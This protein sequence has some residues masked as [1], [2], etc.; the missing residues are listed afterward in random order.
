MDDV[1]GP[2][3]PVWAQRFE[4][5]RAAAGDPAQLELVWQWRQLDTWVSE[6]TAGKSA[7]QLQDELTELLAARKR[8]SPAWSLR[9]AWRRMAANLGPRE[10][11]ALTAYLKAATRFGKTGG[12]FAQRWITEM[13]IALDQAKTAVPV[14]IMPTAKALTS[15]RPSATPP[16]DVLIVDEA[17]QIGFDALPLLSL[18]NT[19]IIVG[20]DKQTSPENVGL[21]RQQIFDMMDDFLTGLP[22]Y[23]TLFDPD[24]SLYDLARERF[25]DADHAQGALPLPAGHHRLLEPHRLRERDHPA[26]GPGAEDRLDAA[27]AGPG[28]RRLPNSRCQRTR[29]AAGRRADHPNSATTPTTPA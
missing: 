3:T 2:P 20:D 23:R 21:D 25:A 12:K 19:A 7:S 5:D 6:L 1:P 22:G 10:R 4:S 18:A 24:S 11:Q 16:F 8:T 14:W 26:P 29:G 13:R 27:G 9:A 17:S 15:F 28:T